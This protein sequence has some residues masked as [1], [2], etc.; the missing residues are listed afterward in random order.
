M[1]ST[2]TYRLEIALSPPM[3]PHRTTSGSTEKP[4]P[5][6]IRHGNSAIRFVTESIAKYEHSLIICST[7][8]NASFNHTME[9]YPA[10]ESVHQFFR[11]DT[12]DLSRTGFGTMICFF[13]VRTPHPDGITRI[14]EKAQRRGAE[15]EISL[16]SADAKL[17]THRFD[18]FN[19]NGVGL[20]LFRDYTATNC[21]QT[22]DDLR[23][24]LTDSPY[25]FSHHIS[26]LPHVEI[27]HRTITINNPNAPRTQMNAL[28]ITCDND[29]TETVENLLTETDIPLSMGTIVPLSAAHTDTAKFA[30]IIDQHIQFLDSHSSFTI[31][32]LTRDIM[33]A[34]IP[35]DGTIPFGSTLSDLLQTEYTPGLRIALIDE[36]DESDSP[37][38]WQLATQ[39]RTIADAMYFV[40]HLIS[41]Y[42]PET[43][44]FK[45]HLEHTLGFETGMSISTTTR[46][47]PSLPDTIDLTS[48]DKHGLIRYHSGST[49]PSPIRRNKQR[50]LTTNNANITTYNIG[51]NHPRQYPPPPTTTTSRPPPQSILK[52]PHKSPGTRVEWDR[53]MVNTE[54]PNSDRGQ[55]GRPSVRAHNTS[56]TNDTQQNTRHPRNGPQIAPQHTNRLP[57]LP[58]QSPKQPPCPNPYTK[59]TAK[60]PGSHKAPQPQKANDS[61]DNRHTSNTTLD[62]TYRPQP[63]RTATFDSVTPTDVSNNS[64]LTNKHSSELTNLR[65]QNASQ[66]ERILQLEKELSLAKRYS[67][68]SRNTIDTT[69]LQDAIKSLQQ[70]STTQTEEI[71]RLQKEITTLTEKNTGL[72]THLTTLTEVYDTTVRK[73]RLTTA[74]RDTAEH[75]L[76]T[77]TGQHTAPHTDSP[78]EPQPDEPPEPK[79]SDP[80]DPAT[81][82]QLTANLPVLTNPILVDLQQRIARECYR[83]TPRSQTSKKATQSTLQFQLK[84]AHAPS[85]GKNA[86]RP[87]STAANGPTTKPLITEPAPETTA[88]PQ[89]HAATNITNI[90]NITKPTKTD[91]TSDGCPLDTESDEETRK[92]PIHAKP[93][94]AKRGRPKKTMTKPKRT[95]QQRRKQPPAEEQHMSA[96]TPEIELELDFGSDSTETTSRP[97]PPAAPKKRQRL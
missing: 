85:V 16:H 81:A 97:T 71:S 21:H 96:Q 75:N 88:T 39:T 27:L 56:Q 76:A 48:N 23:A 18:T 12:S 43:E 58:T 52:P 95:A 42:V 50:L 79:F 17:F 1:E 55:D 60:P 10:Y 94:L 25:C 64:S 33:H 44:P 24:T 51:N 84:T 93:A 14:M 40:A 83:R 37:G 59:T 15:V 68:P 35:H 90:T 47:P 92:G 26:Y 41:T 67:P 78:D 13:R 8:D 2:E 66:T 46:R 29:Q 36:L 87:P 91:T 31:T 65:H 89:T 22:G 61:Y 9:H 62:S 32:G 45:Y 7:Q 49:T 19:L 70:Q 69:K 73:L 74:E 20:L 4:H 34:R 5:E 86:V 72:E 63:P 6:T 82:A 57:P 80:I 30:H 77:L 53:P 38:N 54:Q 11:V 28:V 3:Q